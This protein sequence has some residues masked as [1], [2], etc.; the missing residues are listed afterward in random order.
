[1][2]DRSVNARVISG[3]GDPFLYA[4]PALAELTPSKRERL[5]R[6]H[7]GKEYREEI[8]N[9]ARLGLLDEEDGEEE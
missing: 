1:M 4:A 3:A 6:E 5:V 9:L 8:R 7:F 2:D